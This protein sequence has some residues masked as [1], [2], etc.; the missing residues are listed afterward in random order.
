M[1]PPCSGAARAT[2]LHLKLAWP[3]LAAKRV[4][5][6]AEGFCRRRVTA[7]HLLGIAAPR[8]TLGLCLPAWPANPPGGFVSLCTA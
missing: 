1:S 4:M 6:A 2:S 7:G 5:Q 3:R 8:E